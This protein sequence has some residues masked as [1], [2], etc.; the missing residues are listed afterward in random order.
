MRAQALRWDVV[1]V[2]VQDPVW[3]QSFPE[4]RSVTVPF[5]DAETGRVVGVRLSPADARARRA[6]HEERLARLLAELRGVGLDPVLIGTS[7]RAAIDREFLSWAEL[8]RQARR[9]GR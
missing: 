9:R 5:A 1:P 3:E 6:A 8:R 2:V 4:L 7:D